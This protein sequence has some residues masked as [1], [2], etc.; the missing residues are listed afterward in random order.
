ML[1]RQAFNC[2]CHPEQRV[3]KNECFVLNDIEF[4]ST[5]AWMSEETSGFQSFYNVYFSVCGHTDDSVA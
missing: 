4:V 5:D 1:E 2:L 3:E